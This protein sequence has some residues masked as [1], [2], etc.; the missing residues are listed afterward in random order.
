MTGQSIL[1]VEDDELL[2]EVVASLLE[3]EGYR[4]TVAEDGAAGLKRVA[5]EQYDLI[6]LDLLMPQIDGVRF[7]RM[8]K[9][10]IPNPPPVLVIS[11]SATGQVLEDIT[12]EGVVGVMRKPVQPAL[13]LARV[14]EVLAGNGGGAAA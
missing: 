7:V 1:M 5:Q 14:A 3:L 12:A 13:L 4:V 10:R 11:A 2:S 8:M 9:D 6:L